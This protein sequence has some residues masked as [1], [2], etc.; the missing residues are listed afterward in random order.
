MVAVS[1][2]VHYDNLLQNATDIITKCDS[3]FVRNAT[4]YSIGLEECKNIAFFFLV[5]ISYLS[6]NR[7]YKSSG[8][9]T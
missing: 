2:L 9:N 8:K 1:Y 7:S 5:V 3:F 6:K 4:R